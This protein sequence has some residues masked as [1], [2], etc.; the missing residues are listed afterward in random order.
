LLLATVSNSG[1]NTAVIRDL[2]TS[3]DENSLFLSHEMKAMKLGV[4]E[5]TDHQHH[6]VSL[7]LLLL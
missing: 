5:V 3:N 2:E 6:H 1:C 7:R 4:R